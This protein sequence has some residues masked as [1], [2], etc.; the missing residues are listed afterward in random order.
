MASYTFVTP[1][2]SEGPIGKHRLFYFRKQNKGI[3]IIKTGG[4]YSQVRYPLDQD[5]STYDEVYRGGYNYTVSDATRTALIAGSVG[6]TS[7][8]FT[9]L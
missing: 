9:A 7:D 8:N 5:L 1:T 6:I 4:V 2:V 3:T